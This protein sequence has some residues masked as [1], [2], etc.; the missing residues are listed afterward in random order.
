MLSVYSL[1][2][3]CH[4]KFQLV[5]VDKSLLS[6][7][8]HHLLS[9]NEDKQCTSY[10]NPLTCTIKLPCCCIIELAQIYLRTFIRL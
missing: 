5:V 6:R 3:R 4:Y 9:V 1:E 10:F 2:A 7:K 8:E